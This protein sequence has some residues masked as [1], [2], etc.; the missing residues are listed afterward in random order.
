MKKFILVIAMAAVVLSAASAFTI[1]AGSDSFTL[2][3]SYDEYT[4]DSTVWTRRY[5]GVKVDQ[6]DDM[7]WVVSDGKST[8]VV[9][10][11]NGSADI[12]YILKYSL[13]GY[14]ITLFVSNSAN[15]KNVGSQIVDSGVS[16]N[17]VMLSSFASDFSTYAYRKNIKT[18]KFSS[19]SVLTVENGSVSVFNP[20]SWT[21]GNTRPNATVRPPQSDKKPV[22]VVCPDCG[23]RFYVY[24]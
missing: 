14:D 5:D 18:V 11:S 4:I 1:S 2:G 8:A 15:P 6:Y 9:D 22:Q 17:T 7:L 12:E 16:V 24:I 21:N 20:N 19:G 3:T 23:T 13:K 10:L